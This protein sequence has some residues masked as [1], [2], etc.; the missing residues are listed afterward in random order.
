MIRLGL[1][2]GTNSIGWALYRLDAGGEPVAL[3]DGGVSI[4]EDGRNPR[5]QASNAAQR[6]EKRGLRRNRDRM[7]RRHRRLVGR[8]HDLGLLPPTN[9]HKERAACQHLDPLRLRAAALERAL[10]PY[11]LGHVLLAFVDRRGFKSNR[12]TDSGEEGAIRRDVS[13]LQR[14]MKQSGARTLGEYLWRRREGGKTIRARLGNGLYPDRAMI[15]DE[16]RAIR[17]V[18][19]THHPRISEEDWD[20]IV[21]TILFQRNLRPVK[22]GWCTLIENE[23]RA[24]KA[25]PLFQRF[26]IW[27]EVLNLEYQ[28]P[29]EEHRQL[30]VRQQWLIV[31]KLLQVKEQTFERLA[32]L[33][34]L[35][36]GSRFNLDTTTRKGLIG[37]ETAAKLGAAKCFGKRAWANLGVERQQ[38]VVE[39]LIEEQDY[40]ALISWLRTEFGLSAEAA[41]Q[42]AVSKLPQG[43]GHLSKAAIERLL[44]WMEREGVPYAEAVQC[45]GLGHHS[46]LRGDGRAQR[47]PYYGEVLQREV[48]GGRPDGRTPEERCG[49]IGNP[50]VHIA[51][52]QVRRLFN[53]IADQYGKPDEVVVELARDLKQSLADRERDQQRN[54]KN[55][56]RNDEL[57]KLAADAG[58]AQPS[59]LDMR[60][61]RLWYEQGPPST[62]VCPFTGEKLSI[63]RLLSAETE[64]EH[65]LPYSRTLDD[66]MANTVVAMRSANREKG[67]KTPFEAWA[68]DSV[69]YEQILARAELLPYNKRWRFQADAMQQFDDR[70]GFLARQLND[71]RYLS[72]M[73]KR[74][75]ETGVD[76]N[77]IW[78]TP[79]QLTAMLRVAWGLNSVLSESAQKE[80]SDHRHHLIDAVVVGMISRSL[81][82]RI[83]RDSALGVDD[84]SQRVAK[85]VSDPWEGFRFDVK[86]L[87]ERVTVHHRPDH[88]QPTPGSTTGRLHKGTAYGPIFDANG[89]LQRDERG[90]VLLVETKPLDELDYK[91]LADVRDPALR[92]RLQTIWTVVESE[93]GEGAL[94]NRFAERA[95]RELGVRRVRVWVR[96]PLK[97]ESLALIR[98][99]AGRI[100]KAYKTDGNAYMDVWLLPD[101]K[102]TGETVSRFD[103]HQPNCRSK[104]KAEYPTA[105]KLMRLHTNDMIAIG[106]GS[107]RQFLRIKE[108]SGQRIVSVDHR[109]GGKAKNM[110]LVSK[111]AT[112][113]LV[114]GLRK[115]SVDILGCVQDGGPFDQRGRGTFGRR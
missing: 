28:P 59:A 81:L 108:L 66:S 30:N 105:K 15:E 54:R 40:D 110:T 115:I 34:G 87:C 98:N 73:V 37:D 8:L 29:G 39:C 33:V 104:V 23:R 72:R 111:Q 69:R 51:L 67:R 52:G 78:V 19:R 17:D 56:E 32:D 50:T 77:R 114:E 43:T 55:Q 100:Y 53:A 48:V 88:F 91:R 86:T 64:I 57:R 109:Q 36:E 35:P 49:R 25:Y 44:P 62:R 10:E 107:D 95:R 84:R 16:L 27:Q 71:T 113:V 31:G 61:L 60:K 45:A 96:P 18:Q 3:L 21:D 103:A 70:G 75:L 58:V 4:H 5:S 90:N 85:S 89:K 76:P 101:G 24:Y 74:Y 12:K 93:A 20:A 102:T 63:E 46:D 42:V 41:E 65:I 11:E 13:E 92:K 1:D 7:L 112:R 47:L 6:R 2:L 22:R 68:H 99:D 9:A 14:R 106:E 26:R 94:S 97:E 82:N 79:G 38:Q 83:S 80:R